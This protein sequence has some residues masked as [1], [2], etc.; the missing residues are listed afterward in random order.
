[1]NPTV[2]IIV[3]VYNAEATI[4]R[5]IESII[6]QEYRDFELLL[7]DDGS[8]D[9]SGTICDRYAAEDS[10]IRLI[11]KENTGVSE[12]RN[13]A[14]D[15]A[16]GTYLQFLD[17]DDWITPNA[18]RLFVE[19]A[20]R[21]HCDM[22]ISDF[23]RVVGKR[24]AQKGDIDDDCVLTQEEFSAH[25]LQN[26]ADFYYGVLWNKLYRRDIVEKYHLRMNPQ[27]SWCE[28]FMFNLEYIRHAEVFYALQVPVYYYVK[29]KG[30]LAS[31][32]MSISKTIKMKLMVFEYYNNFYK[33]VL[34]EEDYEKNRLQVYRF[35]VDAAGDGAVP[36]SFFSG[37]KKLG[38]ERNSVSQEVV[39]G[40]GIL[41]DDYRDRKLLDYYLEP[42]AQKNNLTLGEVRL[43]LCLSQLRH[44]GT[45]KEIADFAGITVRSLS[46]LLQR[47][48]L[49]NML[50]YEENRTTKELKITFLPLASPIQ[51]EIA[52]AQSNFEQAKYAGFTEDELIQYA[53]LTEKIKNNIQKIL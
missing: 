18:T 10:R 15:L 29:T 19:E 40:E 13:M 35:L 7:I 30:S 47:L 44:I 17:S 48:S 1:M 37:S 23:Y 2:S 50:K 36:P 20:E 8:I 39:A 52:A 12:T 53:A 28:D 16:C 31:Q 34:D 25:M 5:C 43:L 24:V 6:N 49:K 32:G 4:S 45:R 26:P 21:Y 22:V 51:N 38:E 33:H 27:I 11:H 46:L 42:I 9:S 3:P 41:M 14:L